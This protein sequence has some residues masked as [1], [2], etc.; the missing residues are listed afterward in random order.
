ML[1]SNYARIAAII[2]TY[3]TAGDTTTIIDITGG[4]EA[5]HTPIQ[6]IINRLARSL[7]IDLIALKRNAA[8]VTEHPILQPLSLAPGCTLFPTKV[9]NPIVPGD[10]C[11]GYI[12]FHAV[13]SV[14]ANPDKPYRSTITLLGDTQL[15]ILWTPATVKK[16]MQHAKLV[17]FH[18]PPG[19]AMRPELAII[20][21]KQMEVFYEFLVFQALLHKNFPDQS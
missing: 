10:P 3:T 15:H 13:T 18:P 19:L 9:R 6:T 4:K 2:P 14:T 1:K 17:I 7:A 16:Y 12:N 5:N 8:F 11:M 20:A 21:Q